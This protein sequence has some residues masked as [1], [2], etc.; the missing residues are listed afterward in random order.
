MNLAPYFHNCP[1]PGTISM[2]AW[3]VGSPVGSQMHKAMS[4]FH[5]DGER[6]FN[7]A[8]REYV[9]ARYRLYQELKDGDGMAQV[10]YRR[11]CQYCS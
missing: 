5:V 3:K 8:H 10:G 9:E 4:K 1:S 2:L 7:A 6:D 11:R